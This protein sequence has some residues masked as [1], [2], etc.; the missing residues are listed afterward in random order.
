MENRFGFKELVLSVL[1]IVIIVVLLL[2]MK[3]LD[4]QWDELRNIERDLDNQATELKRMNQLLSK[5]VRVADGGDTGNA[6]TDPF[7]PFD[8]QREAIAMPDYAPATG[9]WTHSEWP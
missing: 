5:G 4:R 9:T 1:M 3:Q 8:R 7:D 6:S 2:A